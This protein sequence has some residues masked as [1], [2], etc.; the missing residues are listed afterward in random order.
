MGFPNAVYKN[1]EN[2]PHTRIFE[3]VTLMCKDEDISTD[4]QESVISF[5]F[6]GKD[7]KSGCNISIGLS[8]TCT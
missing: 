6:E 8:L 2:F 4:F 7:Y 1:C 5:V 3:L